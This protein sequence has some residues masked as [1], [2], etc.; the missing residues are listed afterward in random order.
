MSGIFGDLI[1]GV[2]KGLAG[3]Q[4]QA[5]GGG[6]GGILGQVLA[7]T[8]LGSL[9]GLLQQLQKS[10]LGPQVSSWLGN[11]ANLPISVDQLRQ[12]LDMGIR[13]AQAGTHDVERQMGCAETTPLVHQCM[14]LVG[15]RGPDIQ[16]LIDSKRISIAPCLC[17]PAL[18]FLE[19][20]RPAPVQRTLREVSVGRLSRALDGRFRGE[21]LDELVDEFGH[22][23]FVALELKASSLDFGNVE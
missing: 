9:G 2:L 10:G 17:S 8:D 5:G 1:G 19:R 6:L 3:Q 20:R 4:G 12:A 23:H 18:D 7:N 14:H 15:G 16:A 21:H 13:T 11:G 22:T